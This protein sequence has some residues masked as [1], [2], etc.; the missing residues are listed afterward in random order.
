MNNAGS[1]TTTPTINAI[2]EV[3]ALLYYNSYWGAVFLIVFAMYHYIYYNYI[4]Q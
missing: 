2:T 1:W 3:G 4:K